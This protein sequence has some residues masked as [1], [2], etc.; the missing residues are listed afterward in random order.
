MSPPMLS[1]PAHFNPYY[2]MAE[3]RGSP[4]HRQSYTKVCPRSTALPP[5]CK[6][7]VVRTHARAQFAIQ[8][9]PIA[10]STR[11]LSEQ[12]GPLQSLRAQM[13]AP[14]AERPSPKEQR[15]FTGI[16]VV[17]PMI[18]LSEP[19]GPARPSSTFATNEVASPRPE[20][21]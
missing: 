8:L 13:T 15:P 17:L 10:N 21:D 19:R 7:L 14:P 11:F 18:E 20:Q 12:M 3:P 5:L 2:L 1:S 4:P 16:L 6:T 9:L